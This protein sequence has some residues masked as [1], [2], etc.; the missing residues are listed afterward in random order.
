[1]EKLLDDIYDALE[2]V[3]D[4]NPA[5]DSMQLR[6]LYC[7]D[8]N[9][10]LHVEM[11]EREADFFATIGLMGNS[12]VIDGVGETITIEIDSKSANDLAYHILGAISYSAEE[13]LE[14]D[15]D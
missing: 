14:D 13:C 3:F 8:G 9:I 6:G 10:E 4:D 7:E 2:Q 11:L 1:M 15:E 5:D 12:I